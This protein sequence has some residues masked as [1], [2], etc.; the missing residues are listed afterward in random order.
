MQFRRVGSAVA[1][2]EAVK[3]TAFLPHSI[4]YHLRKIQLGEKPHHIG[5]R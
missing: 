4:Q 1:T 5:L 3:T 2:S